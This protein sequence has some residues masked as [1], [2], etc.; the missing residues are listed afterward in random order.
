VQDIVLRDDKAFVPSG[1]Y[2]VQVL[3][4]ASAL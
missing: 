4:L 1:Y 2:G 3:D